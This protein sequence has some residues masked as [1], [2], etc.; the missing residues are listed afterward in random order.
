MSPAPLPVILVVA[1]ALIF[2]GH[3]RA[4]TAAAATVVL[5]VVGSIALLGA[6]VW[7]AF[8]HMMAV[9]RQIME[10]GVWGWHRIPTIFAAMRMAGASP[11]P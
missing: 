3:W 1:V 6:D 11:I 7:L 4:F 9:Q 5:L 2:G 8:L 10:I